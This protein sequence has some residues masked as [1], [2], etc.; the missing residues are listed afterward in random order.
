MITLVRIMPLLALMLFGTIIGA[1]AGQGIEDGVPCH[2]FSGKEHD[3]CVKVTS[4]CQRTC[5]YDEPFENEQARACYYTCTRDWDVSEQAKPKPAAFRPW[6]MIWQCNDI[7][8]TMSGPRPNV[9]VYDLGG[10][11]WGGSQF[12]QAPDGP[13]GLPVLY[14]NGRPCQL[15]KG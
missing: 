8:I 12:T 2:D 3:R 9:I 10:T 7:R 15:L 5:K 4:H 6:R 14:F 1:H 13:Y 11:I